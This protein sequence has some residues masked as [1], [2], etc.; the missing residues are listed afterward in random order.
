MNP[1]KPASDSFLRMPFAASV[2]SPA[3]GEHAVAI[4]ALR[5]LVQHDRHEAPLREL[6]HEV[7]RVFLHE[8]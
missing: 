6:L 7:V 3:P 5:G 4:L 2:S 8:E 1:P